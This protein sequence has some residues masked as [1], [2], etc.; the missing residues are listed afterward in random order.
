MIKPLSQR[1]QQVDFLLLI[2]LVAVVY[3][4]VLGHDF[5]R[6]YDDNY[7][8][9]YRP[10]VMGFSWEHVRTIF[11]TFHVGN[12]APV[13]ML[14]YMVDYELWGLHA[15]GFLLTNLVI[16]AANGMLIYRLIDRWYGGRLGAL[17]AATIFLIHPV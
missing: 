16:H 4:R 12:Y 1:R 5:Q 6:D 2:I 3:G 13:Q 14:S 11:T 8:V 10:A 7:Y 15:P 17:V 9:L